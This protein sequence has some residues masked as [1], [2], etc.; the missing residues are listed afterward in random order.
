MRVVRKWGHYTE[1]FRC[2]FLCLKVLT[3]NPNSQLSMQR[4]FKRW[5][6]WIGIGCI[7]WFRRTKWHQFKNISDEMVR[8]VELQYGWDVTEDDIERI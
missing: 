1:I 5:E 6:L 8:F 3:F 7:F 2:K 4:H